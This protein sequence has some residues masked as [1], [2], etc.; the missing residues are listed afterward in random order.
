MSFKRFRN[1]DLVYNTIIAKPEFNFIIHSGNVFLQREREVVGDFSNKIKH[2]DQ[3]HVSLHEININRPSGS[4][5]S[6][7]IQKDG[8]RTSFKTITDKSFDDENM[9][10]YG[11]TITQLYPLSAS[12]SRIY[13][14]SGQ[15]FIT[16]PGTPSETLPHGNKKYV[17]ALKNIIES[18]GPLGTSTRYGSLGNRAVNMIAIPGI[19]AG[20][21]VDKGSIELNY[22]V[23]GTLVATAKDSFSDGRLIQTRGPTTGTEIGTVLYSQGL[24]LL[25]GAA[26][27]HHEQDFFFST[28]VQARPSWLSFGTGTKQAGVQLAHKDVRDSSYKLLFK[29]TNKTPSL[30]MFA[31]SEKGEHNH[32]N[33]P[34]FLSKSLDALYV[35]DSKHY[36]EQRREIKKINKSPYQTYEEDF[37]NTTYISKIGLY[38]EN[39]NLIAVATLATPVKKTESRD[40]MFKLKLD[41]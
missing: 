35:Q 14:P 25:T 41:I 13:V 29:G 32:S 3:G 17:R 39:K 33:N 40:Y 10:A 5:V 11:D 18:S 20:S 16:N 12:L 6:S 34:T 7:F 26:D 2:I 15:E 22:Y 1:R 28:S 4:L 8:T 19:F 24:L 30:T 23:T 9:F 37:K 36:N 27:L 38:D 21:K 31:F